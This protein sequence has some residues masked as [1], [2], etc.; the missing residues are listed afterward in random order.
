MLAAM[1]KEFITSSGRGID[2]FEDTERHPRRPTSPR[3]ALVAGA[4]IRLRILKDQLTSPIRDSDDAVAGASIRLRILKAPLIKLL[5][6][7]GYLVAGA[8]IRLRILKVCFAGQ[9]SWS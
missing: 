8:S 6:K 3:G 9:A 1:R 7:A 4:S 2:P 5:D